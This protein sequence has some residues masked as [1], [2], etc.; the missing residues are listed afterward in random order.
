LSSLCAGAGHE[1]L[2]LDFR[3]QAAPDCDLTIQLE[4]VVPH[5]LKG[6]CWSIP[7]PE[8]WFDQY[9]QCLPR[10]ERVLCKTLD[11]ARLFRELTPR[12]EF[13]GFM[14]ADRLDDAV[15]RVR[16]FLHV[17][18]GSS[19][20]GTEYVLEAWQRF[21]IPHRLW[22]I[23]RSLS[24]PVLKNVDYAARLGDAEFRDLAAYLAGPGTFHPLKVSTR[25]N[26]ADTRILRSF[27]SGHTNVSQIDLF[28]QALG[29]QVEPVLM[30]S[31]AKYAVLAAG[32]GFWNA[33]QAQLR[34]AAPP[35]ICRPRPQRC[36]GACMK[37]C[38]PPNSPPCRPR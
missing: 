15:P 5:L 17:P 36:C 27:E 3:E 33:A 9:A 29:V 7:N 14:S 32:K 24:K 12:A 37:G 31:Q 18:G 13:V 38:R 30:D 28:S 26:P 35:P 25:S 8:W 2:A 16:E 21:A 23:G 20:K 34:S 19:V 22:L 11:G 1:P 4:V 10:F 6:R